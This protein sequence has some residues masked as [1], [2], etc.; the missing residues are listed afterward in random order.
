MRRSRWI[1]ISI[2]LSASLAAYTLL[3]RSATSAPS[4][5]AP[6]SALRLESIQVDGDR[7]I[8]KLRNNRRVLLTADARLQAAATRLL[9]EA[10]PLKGA[11]ILL[12]LRRL[13]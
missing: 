5:A 2:A 7:V 3:P 10:R 8:G 11:A 4:Q 13:A 9:T 1:S 12:D 6:R